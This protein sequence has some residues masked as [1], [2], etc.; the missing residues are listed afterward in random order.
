LVE[1]LVDLKVGW[2]VVTMVVMMVAWKVELTDVMMEQLMADYWVEWKAVWWD[3][4]LGLMSV[5]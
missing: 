2:M 1:Q 4:K 3:E 5:V